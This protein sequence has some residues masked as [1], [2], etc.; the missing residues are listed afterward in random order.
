MENTKRKILATVLAIVMVCSVPVVVNAV[1]GTFTT[2]GGPYCK[3][4]DYSLS[5]Q[6]LGGAFYRLTGHIEQQSQ[7]TYDTIK[8]KL[9]L[10]CN[11]ETNVVKEVSAT[12]EFEL[13]AYADAG[14]GQTNGTGSMYVNVKDNYYGYH[15]YT[16]YN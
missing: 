7:Y 5:S 13:E 11:G 15:S 3:T 12:D 14:K 4:W 9:T 8:I 1:T 6:Y 10:F 2:T 16:Y